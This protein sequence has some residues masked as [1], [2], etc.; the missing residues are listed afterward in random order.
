MDDRLLRRCGA[1][2]NYGCE[3]NR[4][5]GR[6]QRSD[7]E[8]N[9]G[10]LTRQSPKGKAKEAV[11]RIKEQIAAFA[12][13]AW[14]FP[15]QGRRMVIE[16]H[17]NAKQLIDMLG[18]TRFRVYRKWRDHPLVLKDGDFRSAFRL[19]TDRSRITRSGP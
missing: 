13:P 6:V 16:K 18:W 9:A 3:D 15:F 2:A 5:H 1:S 17:Y 11:S 4:E 10:S 14:V 8:H 19:G 12:R 7:T